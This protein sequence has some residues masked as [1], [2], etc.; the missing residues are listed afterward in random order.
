MLEITGI[1]PTQP[2]MVTFRCASGAGCAE[3]RGD[4]P[5]STG[6]VDI[7]PVH[8]RPLHWIDGGV[9]TDGSGSVGRIGGTAEEPSDV[10]A[11]FLRVAEGLV[12]LELAA[13]QD[14]PAV[15]TAVWLLD[16]ENGLYS[17]DT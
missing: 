10:N 2:Q 7:Q 12:F 14:L 5:P 11:T 13:G 1:D 6:W 15:G 8:H 17:T 9:L 16:V 4:T 3:W